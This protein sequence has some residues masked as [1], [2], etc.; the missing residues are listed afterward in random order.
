MELRYS[1][2]IKR[3][4]FWPFKTKWWIIE[5]LKKYPA[6]W[7]TNQIIASE[8][9]TIAHYRG[10]DD[11]RAIARIVNAMRENNNKSK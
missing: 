3:R 8:W 11:E 2:V 9:K 5:E 6:P 7:D 4:W 10:K 1:Q